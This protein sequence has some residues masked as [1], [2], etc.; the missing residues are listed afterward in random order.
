MSNRVIGSRK[1]LNKSANNVTKQFSNQFERKLLHLNFN[2]MKAIN[3]Q[4]IIINFFVC[5]YVYIY[6]TW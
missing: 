5:T 3:I 4:S 1:Y 2:P 6:S